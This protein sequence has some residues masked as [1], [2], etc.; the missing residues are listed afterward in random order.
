MLFGRALGTGA[1][2]WESTPQPCKGPDYECE[3]AWE[4]G[5]ARRIL[6]DLRS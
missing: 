4:G 1:P 3:S 2:R 6:R 5:G